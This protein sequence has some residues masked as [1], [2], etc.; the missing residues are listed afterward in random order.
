MEE[1]ADVEEIDFAAHL[2]IPDAVKF[3]L[4]LRLLE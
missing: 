2:D 4:Q 3:K 1:A